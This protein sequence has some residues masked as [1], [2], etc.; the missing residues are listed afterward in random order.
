M[1]SI[2][3]ASIE[4]LKALIKNSI[5]EGEVSC[6]IKLN[7]IEVSE[8]RLIDFGIQSIRS[9]DVATASPADLAQNSLTETYEWIGRIC[10][11]NAR[12]RIYI[13]IGHDEV[14]ART[15]HAVGADTGNHVDTWIQS[16]A[17]TQTRVVVT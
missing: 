3:A 1:S 4:E 10:G 6:G 13:G 15:G 16:D 17:A 2:E 11:V 12:V 5:P 7:G 8:D 14:T 9:I